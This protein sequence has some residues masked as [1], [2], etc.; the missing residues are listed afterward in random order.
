MSEKV[1]PLASAAQY[2]TVEE[3]RER[4]AVEGV[5][6]RS[7]TGLPPIVAALSNTDNAA[8][9]AIIDELLAAGADAS[10]TIAPEGGNV[11]HVLLGSRKVDATEKAEL[12][13]LA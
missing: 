4:L 12:L 5:N 2:G 9:R 8:R 3:V 10:V 11:L 7:V 13:P 6:E 1:R